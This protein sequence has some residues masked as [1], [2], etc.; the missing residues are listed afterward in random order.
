MTVRWIVM[1]LGLWLIVSPFVLG[2][3]QYPAVLW[4]CVIAGVII[5]ACAYVGGLPGQDWANWLGFTAAFALVVAPFY[6]D[7]AHIAPAKW[8]AGIVGIVAAALSLWDP[9]KS[10]QVPFRSA[11]VRAPH[12]G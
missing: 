8:N 12:R 6:L 5:G 3:G 7:Y 1:A 2:T 4:T 11:Q 10:R 9:V